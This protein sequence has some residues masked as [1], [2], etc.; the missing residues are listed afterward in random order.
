MAETS[1]TNA[2]LFEI[3]V[4]IRVSAQ[5]DTVYA[6]VTDLARSAEWSVECVG[7]RWISGQPATVG[8]VFRG[9]NVRSAD[10]V[11]WAPVVRG[12]WSTESEVVEARPGRVFRWAIRD[13]EGRPQDSVWSFEIE[14]HDDG[15]VLVHHF[16]MGVA[17]EG[18]RGITADMDGPT[19]DRFFAEWAAKLSGDLAAT[20][21]RIKIVIEKE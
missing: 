18:I 12:T 3:R 9:D 14:P 13:S 2:P 20:L 10:V 7:G 19:R 11:A 1:T 21:D 5:P 6:V 4:G 8:S 17:T 16:R 15:S